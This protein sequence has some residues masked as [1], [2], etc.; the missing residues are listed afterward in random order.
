M[1]FRSGIGLLAANGEGISASLPRKE[2]IEYII[3]YSMSK[4]L[5]IQAGAVSCTDKKRAEKI[6]QTT[7]YTSVTPPSPALLYAFCNTGTIY[8]QQREKLETRKTVLQNLLAIH[9]GIQYHKELPV[10]ILPTEL[11]E[12][13]FAEQNII[14]SSFA[15]PNPSGTKINR[16]VINALH[17]AEDLLALTEVIMEAK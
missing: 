14:I 12:A 11:D 8:Q 1:L 10:F 7:W 9:T 2:N 16:A 15:Y 17:T 3:S 13:F 6:R 4:A 5:N